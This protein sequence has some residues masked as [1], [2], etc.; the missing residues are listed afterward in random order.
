LGL[1]D[2]PSTSGSTTDGLINYVTTQVGA[3]ASSGSA[4]T[5]LYLTFQSADLHYFDA[6]TQTNL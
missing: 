5:G 1:N 4:A 6:S 2:D 3:A